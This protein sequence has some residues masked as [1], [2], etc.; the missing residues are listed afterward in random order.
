MSGV[1]TSIGKVFSKVVTGLS[2][3]LG[4]AVTGVG[5]TV[6]TAGAASGGGISGALST[7]AG[8]GAG[9]GILSKIFGGVAKV[10]GFAKDALLG[11]TTS[12]TG[13]AVEGGAA[14]VGRGGMLG[15]LKD[16]VGTEAGASMV[17]G[18]GKGLGSFAEAK[19]EQQEKQKDRQFL[20]DKEQRLRD[21]FEVPTSALPDGASTGVV[22]DPTKRPTPAQ[23][24]ARTEYVY[25]ANL[26][27]MVKVPV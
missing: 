8:G 1:L 2:T 6:A 3:T 25:D 15:K 10:G 21:S 16:F 13:A 27:R 11:G 12:A 17:A 22:N 14:A 24:Y 26:G 23:S 9:G 7:F 5:A 19:M 4:S 18:L 20:L